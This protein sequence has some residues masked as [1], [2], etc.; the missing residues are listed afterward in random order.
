M[1]RWFRHMERMNESRLA[2]E[3]YGAN[4]EGKVV[5]WRRRT[6]S[7]QK[8]INQNIIKTL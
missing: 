2:K 3:I 7:N 1:L 4:M 5:K 6:F 8:N